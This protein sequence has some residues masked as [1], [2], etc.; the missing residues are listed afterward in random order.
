MRESLCSPWR[1][2]CGFDLFQLRLEEVKSVGCAL[3]AAVKGLL[4]LQLPADRV[5]HPRA[6]P[7]DDVNKPVLSLSEPGS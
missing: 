3:D 6:R 7:L 2:S 1:H 4:E 5:V